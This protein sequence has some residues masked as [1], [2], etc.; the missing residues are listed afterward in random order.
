MTPLFTGIGLSSHSVWTPIV[1]V[2]DY[3]WILRGFQ[4]PGDWIRRGFVSYPMY[5]GTTTMAANQKLTAMVSYRVL[6]PIQS[7]TIC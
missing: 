1:G 7:I 4:N 5:K 3:D 2:D 6:N